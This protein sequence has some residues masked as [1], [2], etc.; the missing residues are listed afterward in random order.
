MKSEEN[1]DIILVTSD[2]YIDA[3]G[4]VLLFQNYPNPFSATTFISFSIPRTKGT[5]NF[6]QHVTLKIFD[7]EGKEL[8]TLLNDQRLP[9]YYDVEFCSGC[10]PDGVYYYELI[11]GSYRRL[12]KKMS[13]AK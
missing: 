7:S 2:E 11:V 12:V 10:L 13:V 8:L 3:S 4:N 6:F 9:G 5:N 1:N